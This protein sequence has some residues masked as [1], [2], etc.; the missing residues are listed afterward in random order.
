MTEEYQYT[1][2][3]KERHA[4]I[5][6]LKQ[7]ALIEEPSEE[8]K[9]DLLEL[10][11][12]LFLNDYESQ[13][14]EVARTQFFD[15]WDIEMD[16]SGIIPIEL[17]GTSDKTHLDRIDEIIDALEFGEDLKSFNLNKLADQ[18]PEIPF[19]TLMNIVAME[20]QGKEPN[21]ILK[22]VKEACSVYPQNILLAL[23]QD[24]YL[25]IQDKEAVL[26]NEAT[27]EQGSMSKLMN[28]RQ[29]MHPLELYIAHAALFEFVASKEDLLSTDTFLFTS[30]E[31]YPE[32]EEVFK[33]KS[34]LLDLHKLN[35][36]IE[37]YAPEL[38]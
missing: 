4:D 25:I 28:G 23:L 37:K 22:K 7:L 15:F 13:D 3:L 17:S 32:A 8:S 10:S 30:M 31:V 26:L 1:E 35:Y 12:R 18:H 20:L 2:P 9:Q 29:H 27:L 34:M 24:Q 33:Q 6:A 11:N 38:V 21:K 14:I 5:E 16:N 19:Y 36:C